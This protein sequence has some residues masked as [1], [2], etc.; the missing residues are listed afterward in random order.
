MTNTANLVLS[1]TSQQHESRATIAETHKQAH[2]VTLE[3]VSPIPEIQQHFLPQATTQKVSV[4][5]HK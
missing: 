1:D 5:G 2:V 3:D 4:L